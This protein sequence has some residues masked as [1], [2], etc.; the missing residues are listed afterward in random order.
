MDPTAEDQKVTSAPMHN[1]TLRFLDSDIER[2]YL[3]FNLPS[4]RAGLAGV[5]IVFLLSSTLYAIMVGITARNEEMLTK[6]LDS[7]GIVGWSNDAWAL[8]K[9]V[10]EFNTNGMCTYWIVNDIVFWICSTLFPFLA[11]LLTTIYLRVPKF[12]Q[13]RNILFSWFVVSATILG[14]TLRF[15]V[16]VPGADFHLQFM[17]VILVSTSFFLLCRIPVLF[18]YASSITIIVGFASINLVA[19]KYD[20]VSQSELLVDIIQLVL[21]MVISVSLMYSMERLERRYY[22]EHHRIKQKLNTKL[23]NQLKSIH[24]YGVKV[25]FDSPLERALSI[26]SMIMADSNLSAQHLMALNQVYG[27]LSHGNLL[28][29]TIDE[30]ELD[31]IDNEQQVFNKS[32]FI[33]F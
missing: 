18:A 11:I 25:E 27:I 13:L 28:Q 19:L 21:M 9:I 2:E 4:Q 22:F 20:P 15:A 16:V 26:L 32:Y 23:F 31:E 6:R 33:I 17:F 10:F 30:E 8:K 29:P 7:M 3:R 5:A 14:Y 12:Q 1:F 24:Q